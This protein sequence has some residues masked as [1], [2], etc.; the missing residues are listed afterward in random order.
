MLV[1]WHQRLD[2]NLL[3]SSLQLVG[4]ALPVL[5]V[6]GADL[7]WGLA[8]G[9]LLWLLVRHLSLSPPSFPSLTHTLKDPFFFLVVFLS[10]VTSLV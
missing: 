5:P 6:L 2:D 1:A 10:V 3:R 9:I 8:A 7:A 4:T